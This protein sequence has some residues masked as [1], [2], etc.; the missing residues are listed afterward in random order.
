M[1]KF[2]IGLLFII[3]AQSAFSINLTEALVSTY[4]TNP[5]L[6]A[7]REKLKE[8]DEL[9]F[10]A[11]AEFLPSINFQRSVSTNRNNARNFFGSDKLKLDNWTRSTT[12]TNTI[13]FRQNLFNSGGSVAAIAVAKAQINAGR[14]NL[15][16]KEQSI[17]LDGIDAYLTVIERKRIL[18][19]SG[20]TVRAYNRIY[21][22][23][24]ERFDAGITTKSDV[25]Q[26]ESELAQ[27]IAERAKARADYNT[28][29]ESFRKVIGMEPV[30]LIS[31]ILLKIKYNFE[32]FNELSLKNNPQVKA[33][34]Y[35]AD[36][37]QY[38]VR[39]GM[40]ELLPS[41]DLQAQISRDKERNNQ[42]YNKNFYTD[43]KAIVLNF[44]MPI[45]NA[46]TYSK[47]RKGQ[48][49][50]AAFKLQLKATIRAIKEKSC[51]VWDSYQ[52]VLTGY[53]SAAK[54]VKAAKVALDGIKQEYQEGLRTM[55][56]LL[57]SQ[58]R[59]NNQQV[60]FE[61]RKKEMHLILYQLQLMMGKLTAKELSLPTKIYDPKDHYYK[62]KFKLIGF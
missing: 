9:M 47:I 54:S 62:T 33:S 26:A 19:I 8:I 3:Y 37:A 51:N 40:S 55:T 14:F 53:N 32:E 27:R 50:D 21:Q 36:A 43:S 35:N 24:K 29:L 13:S 61:K 58:S 59:L 11:I 31:P 16:N 12:T 30:N 49:R 45:Y 15:L 39:A 10:D 17:L 38:A 41:L 57:D 42:G 18:N 4:N 56:E 6:L 48:D 25:A 7:E 22:A 20:D 46:Q 52:A 60:V 5:E 44:N 28:S 2:F 1:K 34:M 23:A